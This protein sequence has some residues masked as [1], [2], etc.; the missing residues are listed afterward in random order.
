MGNEF[1]HPE[2]IDFPREGNGWS[3]QHARRQWSLADNPDLRY[4]GLEAFDSEMIHFLKSGK[5]LSE[6]PEI[7]VADEEKKILIFRRENSIFALNFNP[8]GSVSDYAFSAPEG[9]YEMAF[10]SDEVRFGGFGRLSGDDV[11]A[12]LPG[13]SQNGNQNFDHT[14]RL[15]LPCRCALVLKKV[16]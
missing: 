15:Y 10:N 7:L 12:S 6:S 16:K 5:I 8:S 13:R 4:G 11:H 1:G 3:F 9:E 2:W 14:M